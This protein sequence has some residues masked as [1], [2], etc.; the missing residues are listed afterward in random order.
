[1]QRAATFSARLSLWYGKLWRRA[2]HTPVP[3]ITAYQAQ[4]KC[5]AGADKRA[6]WDAGGL[7]TYRILSRQLFQAWTGSKRGMFE[8]GTSLQG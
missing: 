7:K 1:M 2:E 3:M 8:A 6:N 5:L 4:V